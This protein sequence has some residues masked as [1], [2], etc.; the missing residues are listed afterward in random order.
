MLGSR[1]A[2]HD[3]LRLKH[4][5]GLV[6]APMKACDPACLKDLHTGA[7]KEPRAITIF[8]DAEL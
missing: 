8:S 2:A 6:M 5:H 7:A 4:V 3:E 1:F